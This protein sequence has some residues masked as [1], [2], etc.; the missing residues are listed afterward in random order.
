MTVSGYSRRAALVGLTALLVTACTRVG[1]R[2][3]TVLIVLRHADRAGLSDALDR[4]GR[5]RAQALPAALKGLPIEVIL[6]PDL[7]RN[8]DT[9]APLAQALGLPITPVEPSRKD[10]APRLLALAE[11]RV[12]VYVGNKDNL[13]PL[14]R[15]LGLTVT[16]PETYGDIHVLRLRPGRKPEIELRRFGV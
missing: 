6:S 14:Y 11:G 8:H 1:V 7:K 16:P 12:A 2:A 15:E 3:E 13:T 9:V 10:F 4:G 5:R